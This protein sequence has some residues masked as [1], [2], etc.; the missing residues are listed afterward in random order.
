MEYSLTLYVNNMRKFFLT[1]LVFL[2]TGCATKYDKLQPIVTDGTPQY[3]AE[4]YLSDRSMPYTFFTCKGGAGLSFPAKQ[5]KFHDSIGLYQALVREG[6]YVL[7]MLKC[8][9]Q[10]VIEIGPN[11][12]VVNVSAVTDYHF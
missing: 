1:F 9:E 12:R 11:K 5:C 4:E 8:D 6:S 7:G 10:L 3:Q 2:A